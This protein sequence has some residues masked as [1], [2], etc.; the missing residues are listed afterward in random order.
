MAMIGYA[1]VSTEEQ[2]TDPQILEL[3]QAGCTTVATE[4]GSGGSR[5]RP[6]LSRVLSD[7]K[8]GD[9][10]VVVRID[11]LA[12]SL[13]HLLEVIEGLE[14]KGAFFRSLRDPIDTS[15][16]QGKFTLQVL[17]AAAELERALIRERTMA[18]LRSARVQGRIGGNP[19]LRRGDREAIRKVSRARDETY[20]D[21]LESSADEWLGQVRRNRPQLTWETVTRL[22][23]ASLPPSST[24]WTSKRLIRASRRYVDN[25][26]LPRS[27]MER[28]P[29]KEK[30]DRLPAII[31]GLR[32]SNPGMTLQDICGQLEGMQI[33]T[34]R[35][36][37]KWYPSS[38]RAILER[39]ERMK[40]FG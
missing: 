31:A 19:A 21:K 15:S 20:F 1:R 6:V 26:L 4:T 2:T 22:I 34:P 14:R 33:E 18:G 3:R 36:A 32:R 24:K 30:A 39:A 38:V 7:M 16:P 40:L 17:G 12:R 23:N 28:S 9:V 5:K 29:R 25:G 10:L 13:S 8:T 27:V 11:R 37:A 35:G